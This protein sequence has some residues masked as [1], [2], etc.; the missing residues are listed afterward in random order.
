MPHI[1]ACLP[2]YGVR[3]ST[4]QW[5]IRAQ[6]MDELVLK[7][8]RKAG[9]PDRDRPAASNFEPVRGSV[10]RYLAKYMTKGGDVG[11]ADTSDG[12]DNLIPHQWWNRS[13]EAKILM[14][15]HTFRLPRAFAAFCEQQ[16]RRLEGLRLG[17]ARLVTVGR[18]L[19]KTSDRS[20]DVLCFQ[21]IGVEELHQALEWFVVWKSDPLAFEQEADRCTS[22]RTPACDGADSGLT[23][24]HQT[25]PRAISPAIARVLTDW[26]DIAEALYPDCDWRTLVAA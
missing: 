9:L 4:G 19:T 6:V 7:A 2:G 26:P 17:M 21:F 16:R 10:A 12:W 5:L 8:C 14:D 13:K 24:A 11:L 15:G 1:H 18:R 25:P 20:I 3:D 23:P 22:L